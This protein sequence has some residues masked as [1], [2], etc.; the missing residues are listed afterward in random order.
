[1]TNL[2]WLIYPIIILSFI[3]A[4]PVA[5]GADILSQLHPYISV[6]GEYSDN[7]NLTAENQK[8]DFTTT[9]APGLKF[10]NMDAQS[11]IDFDASAGH[12]S[13]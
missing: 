7:L 4:V 12:S 6:K 11:G 10:S 5:Y 13:L 2:R 8:K 1:M 9:I 3:W